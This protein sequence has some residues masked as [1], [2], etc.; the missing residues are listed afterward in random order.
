MTKPFIKKNEYG[1]HYYK[2]SSCYVLHREDGPA[3]EYANGD[4][5]YYSNDLLHREGGPA[6]EYANG[7]KE[8]YVNGELHRLD[9]PAIEY[10]NGNRAWYLNG[11]YSSE[12]E[13]KRLVKM[14]NF[15]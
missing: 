1:I 5:F 11:E 3:R 13:H 2:D 12:E 15:L 10:N 7:H 9:G 8:W 4:K 14:I 6:A